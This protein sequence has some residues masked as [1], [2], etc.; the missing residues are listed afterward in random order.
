MSTIREILQQAKTTM[1][2]ERILI[3]KE[4][5]NN[6]TIED[7]IMLTYA[8]IKIGYDFT[9]EYMEPV[10][11]S[12]VYKL[13][14]PDNVVNVDEYIL[15]HNIII[16]A[17]GDLINYLKTFN[18]KDYFPSSEF[19]K[20]VQDALSGYWTGTRVMMRILRCLDTREETEDE[21]DQ[22]YEA[23]LTNNTKSARNV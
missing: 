18:N 8:M 5:S 13:F 22:C 6:I 4:A 17:D 9:F 11:C 21:I 20:K 23:Y 1:F 7:I 2:D 14:I 12:G 16:D 3:T 10:N 15:L 19:I